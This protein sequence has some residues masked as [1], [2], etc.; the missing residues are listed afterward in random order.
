[1]HREGF[2][3]RRRIDLLAAGAVAAAAGVPEVRASGAICKAL[4]VIPRVPK[5]GCGAWGKKNL[6][7]DFPEQERG[8]ETDS[9]ITCDQREVL[10]L[11][12]D[13]LELECIGT[14]INVLDIYIMFE[15]IN[16]YAG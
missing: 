3:G 14:C 9:Q 15:R 10:C 13:V 7:R 2:C 1:M 4:P 6:R 16:K 12:D 8:R 5:V 11:D